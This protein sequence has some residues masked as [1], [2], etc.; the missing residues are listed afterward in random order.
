MSGSGAREW[1][2]VARP[3][4]DHGDVVYD[5]YRGTERRAWGVTDRATAERWIARLARA[6]DT[7]A[8]EI[9]ADRAGDDQA[10]EEA[11]IPRRVWWNG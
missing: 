10:G 8:P 9:D 5:V 11:V 4:N 2:I 7:R 3:V 6:G 1:R